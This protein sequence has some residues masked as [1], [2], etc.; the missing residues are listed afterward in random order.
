MQ[1]LDYLELHIMEIE[2][3]M[4]LANKQQPGIGQSFSQLP[5]GDNIARVG[6]RNAVEP[7]FHFPVFTFRVTNFH[8]QDGL[9]CPCRYGQDGVQADRAEHTRFK[10]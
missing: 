2:I 7:E 4:C 5:G 6:V 9:I 3:G 8:M 10:H 1:F